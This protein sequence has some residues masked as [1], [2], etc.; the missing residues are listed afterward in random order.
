MT[1]KHDFSW[2]DTRGI[3]QVMMKHFYGTG[4]NDS[5]PLHAFGY[6]PHE[7]DAKLIHYTKGL[8]KDL[9][10]RDY[11]YV[12]ITNGATHGLNAYI[13]AAADVKTEILLTRKLYFSFYPGIATTHG[14]I[15]KTADHILPNNKQLGIIDSPSNPEGIVTF[16]GAKERRVWD[17]A[18]YTPTYCGEGDRNN[19]KC[20]P[21]FPE[22]HAMVG[23]FNKLTGI[24]GLRTGWLATND[25]ELYRRAYNYITHD[26]CGVSAL[27]QYITLMII[28]YVDLP[29]FYADSKDLLDANRGELSR[30]DHLFGGQI[31]PS[32]G[33]FALF[34][35]DAKLKDLLERASVKVMEGHN[36]G[37]DRDSVRFNL[38]NGIDATKAMVDAVIKED[39]I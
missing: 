21:G 20:Y 29:R 6:P 39:K 10:G 8:I 35:V 31:I 9:T 36:F 1:Y 27:S 38:A 4:M 16:G 7:G 33:M 25:F 11:E 2:G 37:D 26:L 14:L 12:L 13:Y 19:L 28:K 32:R 5:V 3:R 24:N 15:H 34:E 22:H 17:A 30:L 23:S 18:Y